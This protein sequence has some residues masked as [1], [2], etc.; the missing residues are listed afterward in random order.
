[1][2]IN[3]EIINNTISSWFLKVLKKIYLVEQTGTNILYKVLTALILVV[4]LINVILLVLNFTVIT[5]N[6]KNKSTQEYVNLL[7]INGI[8]FIGLYFYSELP[9]YNL[10]PTIIGSA[11]E[12]IVLGILICL[13]LEYLVKQIKILFLNECLSEL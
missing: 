11:L 2:L 13:N 6:R 10:A 8:G 1:M 12:F 9:L 5:K 4:L 7:V 3:D